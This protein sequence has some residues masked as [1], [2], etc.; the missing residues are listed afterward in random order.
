MWQTKR[1]LKKKFDNLVE[2][3]AIIDE[4]NTRL[5]QEN[6]RIKSEVFLENTV[7]NAIDWTR[8][9]RDDG[10][11][12]SYYNDAQL[13]LKNRAFIEETTQIIKDITRQIALKAVDFNDLRNL[14]MTINGILLLTERLEN[15]ANPEDSNTYNDLN[16]VI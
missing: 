13:I 14:R 7:N 6:S 9:E 15:I 5:L 10:E 12:L 16:D 8:P 1:Q 2:R 4:R 3:F 11:K